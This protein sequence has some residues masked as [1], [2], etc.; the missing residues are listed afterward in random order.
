MDNESLVPYTIPAVLSESP[1]FLLNRAARIIRDMNTEALKPTGLSVRDLGLLR[2]IAAEGP[3]SQQALSDK[4][5]T[6]RTTIVEVIDD[7]E[8]RQLVLRSQNIQDRRSHSLTV[9]PRGAKLLAAANR[10][11]SKKKKEFLSA[12]GEGEWQTLRELLV[13]LITFHETSS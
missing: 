9:T 10:L 8:R 13:R 4:H 12:L 11:T 6:D 3:L 5:K 1:G 7:L 2:I